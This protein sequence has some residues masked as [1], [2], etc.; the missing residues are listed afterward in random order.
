MFKMILTALIAVTMA[1]PAFAGDDLFGRLD[2]DGNK[3]IDR[4]EYRNGAGKL[5]DRL[6]KNRDGYLDWDEFKAMGLHDGKKLFKTWDTDKDGRVSKDEFIRG[7]MKQF[8]VLDKDHDGF[9]D[10]N[11]LD[12]KRNEEGVR[13]DEMMTTPLVIFR[14]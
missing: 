3:K 5:F 11:E 6:D 14:F 1:M 10:K 12:R 9:I 7:S 2:A 13:K 4:K 8:R